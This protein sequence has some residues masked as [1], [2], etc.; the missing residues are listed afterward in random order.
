MFW[1]RSDVVRSDKTLLKGS[2]DEGTVLLEEF[3]H[4][5]NIKIHLFSPR[6]ELTHPGRNK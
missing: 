5:K 2:S 1:R 3:K 4:Y 6:K